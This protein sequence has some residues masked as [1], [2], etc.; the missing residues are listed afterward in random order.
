VLVPRRSRHGTPPC[1]LLVARLI[2]P[3]IARIFCARMRSRYTARRAHALLHARGALVRAPSLDH[4]CGR[5]WSEWR[6]PALSVTTVLTTCFCPTEG[7]ARLSA[8]MISSFAPLRLGS[9]MLAASDR[10]ATSRCAPLTISA[11]ISGGLS[12][13]GSR[14]GY[15][16]ADPMMKSSLLCESF[17][18]GPP[19]GRRR[20]DPR[21]HRDPPGRAFSRIF[22]D[23]CLHVLGSALARLCRRSPYRTVRAIKSVHWERT[24]AE[25]HA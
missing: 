15:D 1:P 19:Q 2:T 13:A 10:L 6:Q 21:G 17:A 14:S 5:H 16:Q 9:P 18:N 25:F 11:P 24:G 23:G 20:P 4:A 22:A 8:V 3:V 7:L 12:L